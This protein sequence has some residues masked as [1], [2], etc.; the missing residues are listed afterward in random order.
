MTEPLKTTDS[1]TRPI[2]E[3][4]T[5]IDGYKIIR[6]IG[7]GGYSDLY[8][9]QNVETGKFFAM[10]TER[11]DNIKH[12]LEREIEIMKLMGNSILLPKFIGTG[13]TEEFLYIVMELLGPSVSLVKKLCPE[14]KFEPYTVLKLA[15]E[16]IRCVQEFHR[17]GFLHRDIKPANFLF[18]NSEKNPLVLVDFGLSERL[19]DRQDQ[20][21]P[22]RKDAGFI[23][24]SSF[25]SPNAYKK[26]ELSRR[27]DLYSWFYSILDISDGRVP[28]PGREDR[29]LTQSM[30]LNTSPEE[31]CKNLPPIFVLIYE[32]ITSLK[33][34]DK[35]NYKFI[36]DKI[37]MCMDAYEPKPEKFQWHTIP[38]EK[39]Q[40]ISAISI[41]PSK[42]KVFTEPPPAMHKSKSLEKEKDKECRI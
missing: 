2:I 4:G 33:F 19:Y 1:R 8:Q 29:E 16:M 7:R 24:T 3:E 27:D 42:K 25:C 20:H 26:Y 23:G 5:L 12:S 11:F 41:D 40:A 39:I 9:V 32:E 17:H 38:E 15:F 22:F 35:P 28:W 36:R 34:K 30:K 6:Q 18:R 14:Q 21:I 31:L 13:K 10:K 37:Q